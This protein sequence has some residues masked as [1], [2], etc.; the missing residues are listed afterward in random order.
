MST[1]CVR[2]LPN[3]AKKIELKPVQFL[4]VE[5][6]NYLHLARE[7]LGKYLNTSVNDLVYVPNATHG[8]NIIAHSLHLNPGD[9]ILTTTYEYPA[10]ESTMRFVAQRSGARI[11]HQPTPLPMTS[12][13]E[14]VDHFWAGVNH[15]TRV[16]W[17]S[18][19]AAFSAVILP[20]EEICRRAR[21]HAAARLAAA[22]PAPLAPAPVPSA[23]R[24]GYF[25]KMLG[26]GP[27]CVTLDVRRS[28]TL[29]RYFD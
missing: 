15:K 26:G 17:I 12:A 9:E 27:H 6:N 2:E 14:F 3:L 18:H 4:G 11:V 13:D 25:A 16:I 8:I 24:P 21:G 29:Q 10:M 23:P 7:E 28:G 19:I 22:L 20:I 1:A 5:L